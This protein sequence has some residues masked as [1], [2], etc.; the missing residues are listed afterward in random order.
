M[1]TSRTRDVIV[2]GAS[3]GGVEALTTLISGLPADL[4]AAVFVVVHTDPNTRSRLAELLAS[5]SALPVTAALHGEVMVRGHVYV[6]PSDNHLTL[7]SGGYVH[8][9]RG[10]RENGHRPSVDLLFRSASRAYG[11]RVI[12]VVLTGYLDCG[13]AGLLSIKA[14]GGVAVVQSPSDAQVP[15]MPRS[16]IEHVPVDHV[17][18]VRQMPAL[19]ERL[20]RE[21]AAETPEETPEALSQIEGETLG[22]RADLVCPT[23]QGVLTESELGGFVVLRCH[24]GHAFSLE[25]LAE[26]QAEAVERA[27]WA[28]VRALEESAAMSRRYSSRLVGNLR[29][30]LA[31][32]E[33]TQRE[34]AA[35]I[36]KFLVGP[37]VEEFP[38]HPADYGQPE[39]QPRPK[40]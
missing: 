24:V 13:T 29:E 1:D 7:R 12:G 32:R 4:P 17:V 18:S 27:L 26:E 25:S 28:A 20:A 21:P 30:R 31:E 11:G 22:E 15:D 6:A 34:Q 5:R 36:R 2:I 9:V 16:A 33:S 23:C 19:L 10:P 8:V 35:V 38:P 39:A 37:T 40:H 3:T 14:R